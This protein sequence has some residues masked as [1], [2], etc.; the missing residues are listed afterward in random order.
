M[1]SFNNMSEYF[2]TT[3]RSGN[4]QEV[5]RLLKDCQINL[6]AIDKDGLTALILAAAEGHLPLVK[7]LFEAGADLYAAN[8]VRIN[9]CL[10]CD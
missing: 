5:K 9:R 4:L 3:T 6:E 2:L 8:S 1:N 10:Y 7:L